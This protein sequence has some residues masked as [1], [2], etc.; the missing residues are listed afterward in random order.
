M[1]FMILERLKFKILG[2]DNNLMIISK[3]FSILFDKNILFDGT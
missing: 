3:D 2:N 1:S